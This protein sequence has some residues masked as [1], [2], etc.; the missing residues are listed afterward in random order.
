MIYGLVCVVGYNVIYVLFYVVGYN[1]I[2]ALVF[3]DY[4]VICGL[5]FNG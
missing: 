5:V 2:Y 1:V 3:Y 4:R